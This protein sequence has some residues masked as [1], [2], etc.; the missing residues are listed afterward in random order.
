MSSDIARC[1]QETKLHQVENHGS[2]HRKD[3]RLLSIKV[4]LVKPLIY[5]TLYVELTFDEHSFTQTEL[6]AFATAFLL[7][8]RSLL[9]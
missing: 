2:K 4:L 9:S 7:A 1:P 5:V 3:F 6:F 8:L